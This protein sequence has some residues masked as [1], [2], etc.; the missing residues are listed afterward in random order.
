LQIPVWARTHHKLEVERTAR[1]VVANMEQGSEDPDVARVEVSEISEKLTEEGLINIEIIKGSAK[2]SDEH[3]SQLRNTA[4]DLISDRVK[5]VLKNRIRGMT[6]EERRSSVVQKITEEVT[7]FAELRLTQ[8]DVIEWKANPQATI[9]DF[10][11]GMTGQERKGLITLV[12]LSN[13]VVS[14]L[15]V[16]ISVT[17]DWDADPNVSQVTVK[18]EYPAAREDPRGI[19]EFSFTKADAAPKVFRCRRVKRDLGGVTY[20]AKAFILGAA[21]PIDLPGGS[22]NGQV[23]VQVPALG[24]FNVAARPHP[25]MFALTGAGKIAAVE[26]KYDYKQPGMPD[27]VSGSR[28][29]R[30]TDLEQGVTINHVT[31][32][33]IDAP[34]RYRAVYLRDGHPSIEGAEQQVWVQAGRTGIV[35]LPLPFTDFLQIGA[36]VPPGIA[37]LK[38]VRVDLKHG[39]GTDFQSDGVIHIE[40]DNGEW[41][42][43]TTVVQMNKANQKF[44]YRYS[45]EGA[46]QL[47]VGPWV[48]AEGDQ[49]I[50]LPLL[51][52]TLRTERLKLGTDFSEAVVRLSYED[53]AHRYKTQHEFFL[54]AEEQQ[55]TWL[56]PRV[57]PN[58]D[59][60]TWSI[61]LHPPSG[62]PVTINDQQ[63]RGTNLILRAPVA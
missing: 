33:E 30:P 5:E 18:V 28:M 14:T 55:A 20:S 36:R 45:V 12:D 24:A 38:R 13:P 43:K 37:G 19:Q 23:H 31:F 47:A 60:Y 7:S 22:T 35:E 1:H 41:S 42:G 58:N 40:E 59:H 39:D 48:E 53:A 16:D 46:D 6:E 26:V 51:G 34:I 52:V 49:Q 63:G 15:E 21:K 62:P 8:R 17:A 50:V 29:V 2:I 4:I 3:V 32:K 54:T 27:H 44:Q 10:L 61:E 9:T 11:G 57:D 56:V 25:G